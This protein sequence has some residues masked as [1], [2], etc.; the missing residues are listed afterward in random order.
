LR[1]DL[2]MKKCAFAAA[3]LLA[4]FGIALGEEVTVSIVRVDR[5]L[6][7]F[8]RLNKGKKGERE[9]LPAAPG[10]IVAKMRFDKETKKIAAGDPIEGGL[11]NEIFSKQI[12][13][14]ITISDDN[15]TITRVLAASFTFKKKEP[16]K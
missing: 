3:V 10:V 15:K 16:P 11:K 14:R 5:D 9:R 12:P 13:A 4:S 8:H 7:T 1:E 2:V 6:I